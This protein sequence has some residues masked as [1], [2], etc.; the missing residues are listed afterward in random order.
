MLYLFCNFLPLFGIPTLHL[1][2]VRRIKSWALNPG[3]LTC[4]DTPEMFRCC[5]SHVVSV[6]V[7]DLWRKMNI[8][9]IPEIGNN[10]C[11]TYFSVPFLMSSVVND[12]TGVLLACKTVTTMGGSHV[13]LIPQIALAGVCVNFLTVIKKRELVLLLP[14]GLK[15]VGKLDRKQR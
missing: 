8:M 5:I 6:T 14:K 1:K 7:T 9:Y 4:T 15:H 10:T 11:T 12:F 13:Q 2:S 3:C